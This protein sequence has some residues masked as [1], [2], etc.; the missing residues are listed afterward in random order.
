M[1]YCIN[2]VFTEHLKL[3]L[4]NIINIEYFSDECAGQYKN[5]KHLYN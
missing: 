2:Q 5:R 1:V 4:P 3:I